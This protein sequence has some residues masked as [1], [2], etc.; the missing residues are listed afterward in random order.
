MVVAKVARASFLSKFIFRW[1]IPKYNIRYLLSKILV[2]KVF[3]SMFCPNR[4]VSLL[5]TSNRANLKKVLFWVINRYTQHMDRT[6]LSILS[7]ARFYERNLKKSTRREI[8]MP[9][10]HHVDDYDYKTD[11]RKLLRVLLWELWRQWS[12][13]LDPAGAVPSGAVAAGYMTG[14]AITASILALYLC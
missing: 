11:L 10:T 9:A 12:R 6:F 3:G 13:W 8:F 5:R 4:M 1:S 7:K 14:F 2:T